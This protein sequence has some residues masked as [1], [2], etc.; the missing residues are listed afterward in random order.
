MVATK[1]HPSPP[2]IEPINNIKTM[3]VANILL[4]C[5]SSTIF[6]TDAIN[7]EPTQ[8]T[9]SAFNRATTHVQDAIIHAISQCPDDVHIAIVPPC[10]PLNFFT[11]ANTFLPHYQEFGLTAVPAQ[12]LISPSAR[13]IQTNALIYVYASQKKFLQEREGRF[14]SFSQQDQGY[15]GSTSYCDGLARII[16]LRKIT[17]PLPE[18]FIPYRFSINDEPSRLINFQNVFDEHAINKKNFHEN[19]KSHVFEMCAGCSFAIN[20]TTPKT[21]PHLREKKPRR[22]SLIYLNKNEMSEM[23]FW[24]LARTY[25]SK[26]HMSL[27]SNLP[28][29][30]TPV[31]SVD[32]FATQLGI[33]LNR[34]REPKS[35]NE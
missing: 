22:G 27:L 16:L 25:S 11:H 7:P 14:I 31:S 23:V 34:C 2:C 12:I 1:H 32:T 35:V 8:D 4:F 3:S 20:I 18:R 29:L 17:A 26:F 9:D 21:N 33:R 6:C 5:V 30:F 10:R 13:T 28:G 24:L 19:F 15:V